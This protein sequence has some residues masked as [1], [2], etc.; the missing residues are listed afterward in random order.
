MRVDA[1]L[2]AHATSFSHMQSTANPMLPNRPLSEIVQTEP[3]QNQPSP[4]QSLNFNI[5]FESPVRAF[6]ARCVKC[7]DAYRRRVPRATFSWVQAIH[8]RQHL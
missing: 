2:A 8:K 1:H 7:N 5:G 3:H 4:A 6:C